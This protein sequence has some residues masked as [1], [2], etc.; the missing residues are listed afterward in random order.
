MSVIDNTDKIVAA[1]STLNYVER[2]AIQSSLSSLFFNKTNGGRVC[3]LKGMKGVGKSTIIKR[4]TEGRDDT[5]YYTCSKDESRQTII[6]DAVPF[7][8]E[9]YRFIILDDFEEKKRERYPL[10]NLPFIQKHAL[11]SNKCSLMIISNKTLIAE[12]MFVNPFIYNRDTM[13]LD[14]TDISIGESRSLFPSYSFIESSLLYLM[15][16]GK[17]FIYSIFDTSL[18]FKENVE[19]YYE[20]REILAQYFLSSSISDGGDYIN[21]VKGKAMPLCDMLSAVDKKD[22]A[23]KKE[24]VFF[25]YYLYPVLEGKKVY[26]DNEDFFYSNYTDMIFSFL[27]WNSSSHIE[28]YVM[29]SRLYDTVD[30]SYTTICRIMR[31]MGYRENGYPEELGENRILRKFENGVDIVSLTFSGDILEKENFKGII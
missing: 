20:S 1:D 9:K 25:F 16:G 29:Y 27:T 15:T 12:P 5:L 24:S 13:R 4:M 31:D 30:K 26:Q 17:A 22:E 18:S 2:K 19:R 3:F 7:W 23:L 11:A 14:V 21:P 8:A 6:N 28:R 10:N